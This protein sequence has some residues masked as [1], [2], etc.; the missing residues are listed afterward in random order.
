[1][2]NIVCFY[3]K[4]IFDQISIPLNFIILAPRPITRI[5]R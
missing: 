4:G 5:S 2:P 3:S 1:M